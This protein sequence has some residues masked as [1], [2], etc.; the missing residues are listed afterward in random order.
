M[1]AGASSPRADVVS[2]ARRSDP[3]LRIAF[4]RASARAD[5]DIVVSR[6]LEMRRWREEQTRFNSRPPNMDVAAN[7]DR[8]AHLLLAPFRRSNPSDK[9]FQVIYPFLPVLYIIVVNWG[10][11][12]RGGADAPCAD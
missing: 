9:I 11:P 6:N 4:R 12:G 2:F 1:Y 8:T 7:H 10:C 5:A 3:R